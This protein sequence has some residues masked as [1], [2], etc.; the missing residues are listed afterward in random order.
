MGFVASNH[1]RKVQLFEINF[2]AIMLGFLR[3]AAS[4]AFIFRP[5]R[6]RPQRNNTFIDI[7]DDIGP[8]MAD[9]KALAM[10]KT[11]SVMHMKGRT[12]MKSGIYHNGDGPR[13]S[14]HKRVA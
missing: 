6:N 3:H 11:L 4:L 7:H 2:K 1:C 9:D 5:K 10:I 13:C 12:R 8:L 14:C